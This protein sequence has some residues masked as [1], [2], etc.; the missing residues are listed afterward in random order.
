MFTAGL[1]DLRG[2]LGMFPRLA[3]A[4]KIA[5][6]RRF[7]HWELVFADV[8][9]GGGRAEDA[10]G[11]FDMI[12]GNPPWVKIERKE[13]E[14]LGDFDPEL[15]IRKTSGPYVRSQRKHITESIEKGR[16]SLLTHICECDSLQ[17]FFGSTQNYALLKGLIAN[18][19]K[20][21]LPQSWMISNYLGISALLH[22]DGVYEDPRGGGLDLKST[23]AFGLIFN[24]ITSDDYF[25]KFIIAQHSA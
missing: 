23:V 8:F 15:M 11:G 17:E 1:L 19:F 14:V 18:L 3:L 12:L 24:S 21:F 16:E 20:C 22:P 25:R 9:Y 13:R 6:V 2:L 7:H 4:T 10:S 5:Q